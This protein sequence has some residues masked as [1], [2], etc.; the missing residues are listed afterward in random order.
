MGQ[1]KRDPEDRGISS[2]RK[3]S[4]DF[5]L[6][7]DGLDDA[8]RLNAAVLAATGGVDAHSLLPSQVS[9]PFDVPPSLRF[10]IPDAVP[11][12][13]QKKT[14][15]RRLVT[16]LRDP[17]PNVRRAAAFDL[18]GW[19]AADDVDREL[20]DAMERETDWYVRSV[21]ML[22]VALR[23]SPPDLDLVTEATPIV[24]AAR[25][26]HAGSLQ[27]LAGSV[28]VLAATIGVTRSNSGECDDLAVLAG[29]LASV[30][31]ERTRARALLAILSENC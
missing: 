26:A 30:E 23:K 17:N 16:D 24:E 13:R 4:A 22:S 29:A 3:I 15:G 25:Q 21:M 7:E 20:V 6:S 2:L 9:L 27:S 28:A 14:P 5:K 1:P 18:G 10:A 8:R 11:E 19:S 31:A 12:T